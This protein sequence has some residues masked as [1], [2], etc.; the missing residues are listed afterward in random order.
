MTNDFGFIDAC[1]RALSSAGVRAYESL[2][3][4]GVWMI[5]GHDK[6]G[7]PFFTGR[8][9]GRAQSWLQACKMCGVSPDTSDAATAVPAE[10]CYAEGDGI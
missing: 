6:E 3:P 10:P 4:A 5:Q 1:R 9:E 8:P 2:T 7:L